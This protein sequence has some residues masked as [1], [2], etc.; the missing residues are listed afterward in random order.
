MYLRTWHV[1]SCHVYAQVVDQ[2]KAVN[3]TITQLIKKACPQSPLKHSAEWQFL[4]ERCRILAPTPNQLHFHSRSK[5]TDVKACVIFIYLYYFW[6]NCRSL[7]LSNFKFLSV[8]VIFLRSS[9]IQILQA[10]I[11]FPYS[12]SKIYIFIIHTKKGNPINREVMCEVYS[13]YI[14]T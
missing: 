5:K 7:K 6:E 4:H 12:S 8:D 3:S 1:I 14:R 13:S 2:N 9:F 11:V 10:I